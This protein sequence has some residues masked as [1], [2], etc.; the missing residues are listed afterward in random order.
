MRI[1]EQVSPNKGLKFSRLRISREALQR[2]FKKIENGAPNEAYTMEGYED[3]VFLRYYEGG[4]DYITMIDRN[5]YEN[6][7]ETFWEGFNEYVVDKQNHTIYLHRILCRGTIAGMIVHHKGNRFDNRSR[8]LEAVTP[9]A[10]DQ[11]RTYFGD[12][13]IDIE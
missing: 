7:K 4:K 9:K 2:Y 1:G 11:H 10:H 3:I 13:V 6:I 5:D 8:T 12:M